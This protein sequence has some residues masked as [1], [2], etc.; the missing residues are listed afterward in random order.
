M[1]R[2][3]AMSAAIAFLSSTVRA[4]APPGDDA[5]DAADAAYA[6]CIDRNQTNA[7]WGECGGELLR[8]RDDELNTVWRRVYG[9][10]SG[11]T[12]AQLLDEQRA[13]VRYK[14]AS[15]VYYSNGEFGREGQVLHFA[16]C[17]AEVIRRRITQLKAHESMG[18]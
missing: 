16:G 3:I 8:Q 1:L 6:A 17:R 14:D 7:A 4:E 2:C 10:Q 15:C 18:D 12:K 9:R 5:P 13:W 11:Q